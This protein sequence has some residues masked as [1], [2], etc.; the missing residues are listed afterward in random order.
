MKYKEKNP[1]YNPKKLFLFY[2]RHGW[3]RLCHYTARV[4]GAPALYLDYVLG[5]RCYHGSPYDKNLPYE[6]FAKEHG[7][8]GEFQLWRRARK[9][10]GKDATWLCNV[11]LPKK[12]GS[13]C[14]VDLVAVT[15]RG[16]F[17]FESKNYSGWIYA[18]AK[19]P[20]WY[21]MIRTNLRRPPK[22]Y[23]FFSPLMQNSMHLHCLQNVLPQYKEKIYPYT[24]F[25][26]RCRL[27]KMDGVQED[28]VCKVGKLN[29]RLKKH[30]KDILVRKEIEII[31]QMLSPYTRITYGDKLKHIA[32]IQRK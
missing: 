7:R 4:V 2:L 12:D 19:Q 27:K 15:T 5:K 31:N 25:G 6:R 18:D 22:K 21:Q 23:T 17:V 1:K 30:P 13:T 29:S 24:V 28:A 14:E 32:N 20:Y 26:N 9:V 16:I 3:Y 11:Y 10:L 8:Y